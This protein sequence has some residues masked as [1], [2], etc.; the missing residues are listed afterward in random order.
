MSE[1]HFFVNSFPADAGKRVPAGPGVVV[2]VS[3]IF[4]RL[5]FMGLLKKEFL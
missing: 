2:W 1:N 3:I 5:N 4:H